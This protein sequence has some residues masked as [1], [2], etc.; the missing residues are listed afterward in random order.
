[1]L[2][3]RNNNGSEELRYLTGNYYASNDFEKVKID[4]EIAANELARTIGVEL[5]E[6]AEELY[7]SK[8]DDPLI[9]ILRTPI[10]FLATL[11]MYRKND[12]SHEDSGR[13]IK[14]DADS[15]KIPW[16]WQIE[17]DNKLHME[18]YYRSVDRL[19][20][21]LERAKNEIWMNSSQRKL[22]QSLF[23]RNAGE[24]DQLFPINGSSR[25]YMLLTPFIREAERRYIKPAL[26]IE[27]YF[28]LK[29]I[30]Q[31][32]EKD[33]E[34][35]EYVK[36]PIPLLSMSIAIRRMPLSVIP[37]GVI[38]NCISESQTMNSAEAPSI[39]MIKEV[40]EWLFD[41]AMR[42]IEDMKVEKN[43][44]TER[45]L[46]SKNNDHNKYMSIY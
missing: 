11:N 22:S 6:K 14:I 25:M 15:E 26:G 34:L 3:N 27:E 2:F 35:L 43:G 41:D 42:L 38:Q 32:T 36:A 46:F 40:S 39:N 1:M 44:R 8:L 5:I 37:F 10:A 4:L 16:E 7:E 29:Q 17:N 19:I 18:E 21:Y 13:K 30:D 24:F 45:Q 23:I 28:R 31:L 9:D 20:D 33:M 12:I